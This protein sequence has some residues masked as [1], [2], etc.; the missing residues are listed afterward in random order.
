MKRSENIGYYVLILIVA[1][2]FLSIYLDDLG[3][4]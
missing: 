3:L 1:I 4:F 2:I